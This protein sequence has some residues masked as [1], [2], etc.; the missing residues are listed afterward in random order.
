MKS[1]CYSFFD[2]SHSPTRDS[3]VAETCFSF[4]DRFLMSYQIIVVVITRPVIGFSSLHRS[5]KGM[6]H[7]T[8]NVLT[9]LYLDNGLLCKTPSL[10]HLDLG[11]IQ[12]P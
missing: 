8:T 11:S 12:S 10:P 3:K 5:C 2:T 7:A 9:V 4:N 6:I 1:T